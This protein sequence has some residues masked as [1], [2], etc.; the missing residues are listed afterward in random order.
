[1]TKVLLSQ[2]PESGSLS[3]KGLKIPL[4]EARLGEPFLEPG[5]EL[6]YELRRVYDKILGNFKSRGRMGLQCSRCLEDFEA[7]AKAEFLL[8]FEREPDEV[9]PRSGPDPDDAELNVVFFS[10]DKLDFGEELRQEMELQVPFAP[11]C[12]PDC[13]GL[14]GICGTPRKQGCD[15][16][17]EPKSGPFAGLKDLFQKE[18]HKES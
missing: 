14:C 16:K 9:N 13:R 5:L 12:S 6:D 17:E 2:I 4:D 3:E 11:L 10:G 8:E 1:V 7:D 18:K 15:C